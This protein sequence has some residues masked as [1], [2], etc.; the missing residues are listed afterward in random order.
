MRGHHAT[1]EANSAQISDLLGR[2]I[3]AQEAERSRIA[4]D[5]HDDV[6]QRIAGL[7]IMISRVKRTL[8]GK[9]DEADV[10]TAL[11]S[12][13]ESVLSLADD[14]RT[15]IAVRAIGSDLGS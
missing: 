12:M 8:R 5:L 3:D 15:R 6:S 2:L 10:T 9:P 4:R 7:S 13:Q 14:T 11:T 1:P